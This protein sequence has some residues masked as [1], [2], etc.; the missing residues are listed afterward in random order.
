MVWAGMTGGKVAPKREERVF[1]P[2]KTWSHA[3]VCRQQGEGVDEGFPAE[4]RQSDHNNEHD[5]GN[6]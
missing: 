5:L 6:D 2:K 4:G 1:R 3:L